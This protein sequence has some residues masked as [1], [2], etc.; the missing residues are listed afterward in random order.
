MLVEEARHL[1]VVLP[2]FGR[3]QVGAVLAVRLIFEH[4]KEG[5]STPAARNLRCMRTLLREV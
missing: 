5:L 3:F 4:L 1:I 2:S